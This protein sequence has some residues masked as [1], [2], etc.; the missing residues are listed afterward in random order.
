MIGHAYS[1]KLEKL[2][3]DWTAEDHKECESWVKAAESSGEEKACIEYRECRA[4]ISRRV[5]N[6]NK[7]TGEVIAHIVD[8]TLYYALYLRLCHATDASQI[9]RLRLPRY[10]HRA[11]L[12]RVPVVAVSY[13]V[14]C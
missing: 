1:K 13:T 8:N 2:I 9:L 11:K 3:F 5:E 7:R 6:L 4:D 12:L 14:M 10:T